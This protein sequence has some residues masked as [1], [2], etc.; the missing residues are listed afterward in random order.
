MVQALRKFWFNSDQ[1]EAFF[2]LEEKKALRMLEY[3]DSS[4]PFGL[5]MTWRHQAQAVLRRAAVPLPEV[6]SSEESGHTELL[7]RFSQLV[8]KRALW[9][10]RVSDY[11]NVF[12][13]WRGDGR[14]S[15]ALEA[16][17]QQWFSPSEQKRL[18]AYEQ[19]DTLI[20]DDILNLRIW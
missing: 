5:S 11:L 7:E 12:H 8:Q 3:L 14:D 4:K 6:T 16:Y 17:R 15:L 20:N 13:Q 19:D 2:S 1:Y 18:S 10:Q 9:Y